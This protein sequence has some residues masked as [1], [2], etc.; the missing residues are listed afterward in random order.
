LQLDTTLSD[1]ADMDIPA[2]SVVTVVATLG[3][4]S[5]INAAKADTNKGDNKIYDLNGR[6]LSRAQKGIYIQNGKKYIAK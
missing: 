5:G 3:A 2:R 1:A 6:Q 4:S